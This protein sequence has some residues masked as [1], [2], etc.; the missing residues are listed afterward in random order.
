MK[1]LTRKNIPA[2]IRVTVVGAIVNIL[3][4]VIK[5]VFGILG[6][7][8]AL[9]A[10]AVHSMSDLAS[11][12]VVVLGLH[13]GGQ[14]ADKNHHYG[15]KKIETVTEVVLGIIL[16]IVAIKLAYDAAHAI[17]HQEFSKPT[18]ITVI[19]AA[20]SVISKEWLFRWTKAVGIKHDSRAILANAWHHRSDAL[21]SIAVV[22]GFVS[23]KL[24]FDY[25]DQVAAIAVGLMIIL[26]ASHVIGN[27]LRELT[28]GAVDSGTIE[29]I[30]SVINN[31]AQIKHWHKLRTRT[32]GREVFLDLHILVDP[33]LSIAAAHEISEN[34]ETA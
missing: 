34:L 18:A 10:D 27:C 30:K 12:I 11:D 19:A 15:H 29:H 20:I 21:S 26:V 31:N 23:L 9:V 7:S 22:I 32:V 33:A 5:F 13:F 6:N 25:G 24:G 3:L 16:L 17:L 4:A 8:R 2:G 28:E 14:P 1:I